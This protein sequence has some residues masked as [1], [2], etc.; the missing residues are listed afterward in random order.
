MVT[1]FESEKKHGFFLLKTLFF[2]TG[3]RQNGKMSFSRF[4]AK[5]LSADAKNLFCP[6]HAFLN[7]RVPEKTLLD[8]GCGTGDLARS[9]A[10]EGWKTVGVDRD[11][12]LVKTARALAR[13]S[14]ARGNVSFFAGDFRKKLP[15]GS[16]GAVCATYYVFN[17]VETPA[18]LSR[19]FQKVHSCL[20]PGG[21]FCFDL[22]TRKGLEGWRGEELFEEENWRVRLRWRFTFPH[23]TLTVC[24]FHRRRFFR[25]RIAQVYHDPQKTAEA[26]KDAGFRFQ[27]FF[28][29]KNFRKF[30]GTSWDKQ[31][32]VFLA[33]RKNIGL[34]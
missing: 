22:H 30:P 24:G 7:R 8:L 16:F 5:Y 14:G 18:D 6:L 2:H 10:R 25:K 27:G 9:F 3:R 15:P 4:Y 21:F 1:A 11:L 28:A 31:N 26:L 23:A 32:R 17:Q 20:L 29:P 13:R 19:V 33:A 12:E 34:S